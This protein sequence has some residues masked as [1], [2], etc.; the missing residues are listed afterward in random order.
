M[1]DKKARSNGINLELYTP[2]DFQPVT[3]SVPCLLRTLTHEMLVNK[4]SYFKN[5]HHQNNFLS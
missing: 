5:H 4:E 2:F 1:L 3:H